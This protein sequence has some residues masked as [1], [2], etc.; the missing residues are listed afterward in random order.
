MLAFESK[1]KALEKGK[2]EHQHGLRKLYSKWNELRNKREWRHSGVRFKSYTL[3]LRCETI[4]KEGVEARLDPLKRMLATLQ[5][6]I[7]DVEE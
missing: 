2:R 7:T 1:L 3:A 4:S 6:N 5:R